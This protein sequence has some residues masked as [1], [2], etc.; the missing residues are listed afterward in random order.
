MYF[1]SVILLKSS[2]ILVFLNGNSYFLLQ[3]LKN[4]FFNIYSFYL[5]NIINSE[6]IITSS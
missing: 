6:N 3:Q 2:I 5:P 1:T 4:F